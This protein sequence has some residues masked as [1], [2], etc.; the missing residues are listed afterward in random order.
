MSVSWS[1]LKSAIKEAIKEE[2]P[3]E[4]HKDHV[5]SCPNCYCDILEEMKKTSD[6]ECVGCGLPLGKKEF[7]ERIAACPLCGSK[8]GR[9]IE[10]W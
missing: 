6:Y 7:V 3:N 4:S 10:R 2:Q 8:D 1:E 5:C 9:K